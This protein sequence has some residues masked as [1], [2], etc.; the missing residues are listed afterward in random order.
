MGAATKIDPS[1]LAQAAERACDLMKILGHKDR[2]LILCHLLDGEKSVG[3]LAKL[4]GIPQSPL[5]QHLARM[6]QQS[7]VKTRREAQ[8][9]FYSI[10]SK[11]AA[12]IVKVLSKL[13][14]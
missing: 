3:E 9:I 10:D 12:A 5:S 8:S 1:S 6:R 11:E 7:L 2:L 14:C 13:Y 4:L